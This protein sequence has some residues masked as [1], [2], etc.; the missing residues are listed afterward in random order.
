MR[1]GPAGAGCGARTLAE[2]SSPELAALPAPPLLAVPVGSVEQHGPHLPLGTDTVVACALVDRLAAARADVVCA[3]PVWYGASGEH[4]GFAGTLS[5]GHDALAGLLVELVRSAR[6]SF[7][8]VVLVSGHGGNAEALRRAVA[9]SNGEGDAV[10]GW[11][12]RLTGADAHAG[13]SETALMLALAPG[14]VRSD[15]A[16]PGATE[17]LAELLPR[18]RAAGVR[19]VSA[20]GVLGD[21]GGASAAEGERLFEE[22]AADLIRAVARWRAPVA[23]GGR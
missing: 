9:R 4:E 8:G 15:A 18:L 14:L 19:A 3:P 2:A 17:P 7:A 16:V 22:L 11:L 23:A 13:R 12:G 6:A 20:N 21:P 5:I 1:R 10:L